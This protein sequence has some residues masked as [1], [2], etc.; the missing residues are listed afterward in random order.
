MGNFVRFL[1]VLMT[2]SIVLLN[3]PI[4]YIKLEIVNKNKSGRIIKEIP[5]VEV[6]SSV[7]DW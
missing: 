1:H 5:V 3:Y 2:V 4:W 7:L 6:V